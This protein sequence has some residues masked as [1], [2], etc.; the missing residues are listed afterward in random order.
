MLHLPG[1]LR[2]DGLL[3]GIVVPAGCAAVLLV[4]GRQTLHQCPGD[5]V[6]PA[7]YCVISADPERGFFLLNSFYGSQSGTGSRFFSDPA[8]SD[9]LGIFFF[10]SSVIQLEKRI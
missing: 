6:A 3:L 7:K 4:S 5:T 8:C 1:R 10:S 9:W 2:W